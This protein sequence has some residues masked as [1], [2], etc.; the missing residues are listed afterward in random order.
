MTISRLRTLL[1]TW[2]R[3]LLGLPIFYKV[4]IANS[5]IVVGGAVIGTTL[6]LLSTGNTE[7]LPELVALFATTGTLLSVVINWIVL[8]AAFQ[9]IAALEETAD[10][11]R[12][13]NF[14]VRAPSVA[15]SDPDLDALTATFNAML[16]TVVAYQN[17]L[18]ELSLRVLTAQEEERRRIARE[19]HDDT[20]QS[21][22]AHLLRLKMLEDRGGVTD[23]QTLAELIS[24]TAATLE[25]IRAIAHE[26]RPP[27]LDDLG[28]PA[29]LEGLAAQQRQRFGLPVTVTI[30]GPRRRL[31]PDVE[32]ALYRIAQEA[33]TNVAKHAQAGQ[34]QLQLSFDN[35]QVTLEIRDDGR[36]FDVGQLPS[37]HGG[38]GLFSMRE[39]AQLVGAELT[40][41][42]A[43]GAGTVVRVTAPLSPQAAAGFFDHRR[44]TAAEAPVTTEAHR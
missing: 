4:L 43:P 25:S 5:V 1:P 15:F 10:Q 36:G 41:A 24:Q 31:D 42:S 28:L 13:G 14:Q 33:L 12:Q 22:T 19:L 34:A 23:S 26:L 29:A 18:R 8:R 27:S 44:D 21:L 38:L 7:H 3:R 17:R 2:G 39:R 16:D 35:G 37:R 40:L 30:R 9:P 11:V 32:L 6:T 20:A